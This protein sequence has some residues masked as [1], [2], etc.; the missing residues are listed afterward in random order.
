M[1]THNRHHTRVFEALD[2]TALAHVNT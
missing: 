1:W 2:I